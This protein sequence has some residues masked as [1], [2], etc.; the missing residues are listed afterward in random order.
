M[1]ADEFQTGKA[2]GV[3]HP[4]ATRVPA[5]NREREL[6]CGRSWRVFGRVARARLCVRGRVGGAAVAHAKPHLRPAGHGCAPLVAAVTCGMLMMSN[7]PL[8]LGPA[9]GGACGRVRRGVSG[10]AC[11]A[12]GVS[13]RHAPARSGPPGSPP[14]LLSGHRS[15]QVTAPGDCQRAAASAQGG[16]GCRGCG[17]GQDGARQAACL[18]RCGR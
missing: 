2:D 11:D 7:A 18:P 9:S 13:Q 10:D 15:Q 17:R 14:A 16:A 8:C 12:D 4:N 6:A 1:P 3:R 5:L